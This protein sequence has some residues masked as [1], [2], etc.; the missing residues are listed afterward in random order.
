MLQVSISLPRVR[1]SSLFRIAVRI[2]P[3]DRERNFDLILP[4]KDGQSRGCATPRW[5]RS[6]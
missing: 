6:N 4:D 5:K 3:R 2:P 1:M